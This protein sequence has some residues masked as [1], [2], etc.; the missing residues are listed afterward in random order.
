M[1]SSMAG[2]HLKG[3]LDANF[4]TAIDLTKTIVDSEDTQPEEPDGEDDE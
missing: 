2:S 3:L 4:F 1:I